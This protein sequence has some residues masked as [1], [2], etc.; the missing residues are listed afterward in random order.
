MFRELGNRGEWV[1]AMHCFEFAVGR[2]RKRN[3]QG[4]LA[5]SII[6]IL[7]RSGKFNLAEKVFNSAVKV[8]YTFK[9]ASF[10][11]KSNTT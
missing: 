5:S 11:P 1:A 3:E 4:K 7:G 9:V 6:S 2:E 8:D 10:Q